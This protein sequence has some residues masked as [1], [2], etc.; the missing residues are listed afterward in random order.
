MTL[1]QQ[2]EGLMNTHRLQVI[3]IARQRKSESAECFTCVSMR[4]VDDHFVI[5][6][7][8]SPAEQIATCLSELAAKRMSPIVVPELEVA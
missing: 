1:E 6:T 5:C 3:D 4:S 7:Q 8:G 2:L